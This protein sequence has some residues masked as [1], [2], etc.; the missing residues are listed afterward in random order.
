MAIKL[1]THDQIRAMTS[2][3]RAT[4]YQNAKSRLAEG[5]QQIIDFIDSEGLLLS[6]GEMLSSDPD[7]AL[8]EDIIW[9]KEGRTAAVKAVEEGL[10][11]LAGVDPMIAAELGD[12]YHPHNGGTINAGVISRAAFSASLRI[13]S[14]ALALIWSKPMY[15]AATALL[16]MLHPDVSGKALTQSEPAP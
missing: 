16:R 12:R 15:P 11:A 10:P 9:S 14:G 2:Q 4:L 7:Y 1:P 8:M 13:H 6:D 5:G 3:Q